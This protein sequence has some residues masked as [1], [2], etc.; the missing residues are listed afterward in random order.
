MSSSSKVDGGE[1]QDK[2]LLHHP[3]LPQ[4]NGVSSSSSFSMAGHASTALQRGVGPLLP[5]ALHPSAPHSNK[6][7]HPPSIQ[8]QGQGAGPGQVHLQQAGHNISGSNIP[9]ATS[10]S[11]NNLSSPYNAVKMESEAVAGHPPSSTNPHHGIGGGSSSSSSSS[12]LDANVFQAFHSFSQPSLTPFQ[13]NYQT[14]S[15]YPSHYQGSSDLFESP[16][17]AKV[18][19]LNTQRSTLDA[20]TIQSLQSRLVGMDTSKMQGQGQDTKLALQG[21]QAGMLI[22]S[23]NYSSNIILQLKDS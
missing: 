18:N 12:K 17:S 7:H 9:S 4:F 13:S 2:T 6:E 1:Q 16:S 3:P 8:Q 19:T 5:F 20:A 23:I 11:F 14:P 22:I 21:G 15:S 10:S